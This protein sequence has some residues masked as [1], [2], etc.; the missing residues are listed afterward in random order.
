MRKIKEVLRLR[1]SPGRQKTAWS[2]GYR[3]SCL[4]AATST[5]AF[6]CT[7][8]GMATGPLR[9]WSVCTCTTISQSGNGGTWTRASIRQSCM[10]S[11]LG[12]NAAITG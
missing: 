2:I 6:T 8:C 10:P 3:R 11:H 4:S 12:A 1:Q 5:T 7:S 9:V